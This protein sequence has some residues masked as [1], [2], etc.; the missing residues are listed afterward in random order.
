MLGWLSS[1]KLDWGSYI[2]FAAKTTTTKIAVLIH[3]IKF[4]SAEFALYLYK[5]TRGIS[6]RSCL[7]WCPQWCLNM[8][9]K[10][11]K[12]ACWTVGPKLLLPL[13]PWLIVE[14]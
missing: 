6:M 12:E 14:T 2:V 5:Y 13:N 3:S 7:N 8:L 11:Q 4:S 9:D 10:I 1:S